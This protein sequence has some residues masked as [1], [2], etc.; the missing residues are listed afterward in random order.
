[1]LDF[2][3]DEPWLNTD[4]VIH[5]VHAPGLRLGLW[6]HALCGEQMRSEAGKGAEGPVSCMRCLSAPPTSVHDAFRAHLNV[7]D[8]CNYDRPCLACQ[9]DYA[10]PKTHACNCHVGPGYGHRLAQAVKLVV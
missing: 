5:L 8:Q 1:M 3:F 7:C 2:V 10:D 6:P 4:G 9:A